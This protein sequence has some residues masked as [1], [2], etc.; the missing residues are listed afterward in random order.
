MKISQKYFPVIIIFIVFLVLVPGIVYPQSTPV[1]KDKVKSDPLESEDH[2]AE[3]IILTP[4]AAP[5]LFYDPYGDTYRI[6]N[7]LMIGSGIIG[8]ESVYRQPGSNYTINLLMGVLQRSGSGSNTERDLLFGSF[9][10]NREVMLNIAGSLS[11]Q[12]RSEIYMRF[13][14]GIGIAGRGIFEDGEIKTYLGLTTSAIL[15][16]QYQL[17]KRTAI[18]MHGG[19]QMVWFP[20]LSEIGIMGRP[21]ISIGFQFSLT[22]GILP[23]RY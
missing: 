10:L 18:F 15:G 11:E 12:S 9:S 1:L 2:N 3:D 17:S 22:S 13:G 4:V 5:I 8:V 19:G 23:V 20:G 14:P 6:Q 7:G 21:I 16:A